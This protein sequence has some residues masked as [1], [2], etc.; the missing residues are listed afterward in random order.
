[1]IVSDC[2]REMSY[3][4]N[5]KLS[6]IS[7]L[8]ISFASLFLVPS[9]KVCSKIGRDVIFW[10][11]HVWNS[12]LCYQNILF[13][14]K[15][16]QIFVFCNETDINVKLSAFAKL[17]LELDI[18]KSRKEIIFKIYDIEWITLSILRVPLWNFVHK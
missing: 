13:F 12:I 7:L 5:W 8:I 14:I 16:I 15:L 10:Q 11:K 18:F 3:F 2:I 9:Q 6:W 17:K 4:E 1:M